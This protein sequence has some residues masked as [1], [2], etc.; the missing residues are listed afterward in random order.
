MDGL[1]RFI[2]TMEALIDERIERHTDAFA[3]P[4]VLGAIGQACL[5]FAVRTPAIVQLSVREV[6]DGERLRPEQA[7]EAP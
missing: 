4:N 7:P 6:S 5:R 1:R 3:A 2:V